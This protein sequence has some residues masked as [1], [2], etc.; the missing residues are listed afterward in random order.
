MERPGEIRRIVHAGLRPW[1]WRR[2]YGKFNGAELRESACHVTLPYLLITEDCSNLIMKIGVECWV[3]T[4][5]LVPGI[6]A[7][8]HDRMS[9]SIEA[10][11]SARESPGPET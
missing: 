4:D 3:Q 6:T 7:Y 2:A 5:P 9:V 10:C 8:H 11:R 1:N